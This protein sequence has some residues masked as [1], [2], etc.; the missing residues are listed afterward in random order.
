[1]TSSNDSSMKAPKLA[2]PESG[3]S[4]REGPLDSWTTADFDS[5]RGQPRI[6]ISGYQMAADVLFAHVEETGTWTETLFL[7]LAFLWRHTIEL[8]LKALISVA[9][10]FLERDGGGGDLIHHKLEELWSE[11]KPFI[12][13]IRPEGHVGTEIEDVERLIGQ[14]LSF[15]PNAQ[16]FRYHKDTKNK[17]TLTAVPRYI[18]LRN[19]QEAMAAVS[20]FI[21]G[22]CGV[23]ESRLDY[24]RDTQADQ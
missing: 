22:C 4:L 14:L 1:M 21:G 19:F 15:D 2:W 20:N 9:R 10:E 17:P 11:A 5:V 8:Q 13:E 3:M 18:D 24:K 6:Y 23:Y 12:C 7:P 16:G